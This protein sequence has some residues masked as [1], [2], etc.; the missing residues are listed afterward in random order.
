MTDFD[1]N[2]WRYGCWAD[3][4]AGTAYQVATW[5]GTRCEKV[6]DNGL[7][8]PCNPVEPLIEVRQ[9]LGQPATACPDC[10]LDADGQITLVDLTMARNG[11]F[12][13]KSVGVGETHAKIF[14]S[15]VDAPGAMVNLTQFVD[16]SSGGAGDYLEI[17]HWDTGVVIDCGDVNQHLPYLQ[18]L[19]VSDASFPG[20]PGQ[21][22]ADEMCQLGGLAYCSDGAMMYSIGHCHIAPDGTHFI[23]IS[24]GA[25]MKCL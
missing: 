5:G 24:A 15:G 19:T 7:M 23:R 2:Q 21:A 1:M 20:K 22:M 3:T 10:D 4:T 13:P 25:C 6:A 9:Y 12:G 14:N 8:Q 18:E 17:T 16:D 11:A